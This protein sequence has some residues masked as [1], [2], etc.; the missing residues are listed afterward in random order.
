MF[1][2]FLVCVFNKKRKL[3]VAEETSCLH[4]RELLKYMYLFQESV[5]TN[6]IIM[7]I[8]GYHYVIDLEIVSN[9]YISIDISI[10]PVYHGCLAKY[11]L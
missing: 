7:I 1:L 8:K 3:F 6:I 5:N 4:K 2:S 11:L 9:F 10:D